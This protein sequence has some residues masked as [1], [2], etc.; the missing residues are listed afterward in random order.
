MGEPRLPQ[1][2]QGL[3]RF[4]MQVGD[5]PPTSADV[6]SMDP[7]RARWLQEAMD[8]L[9]VDIGKQLRERIAK[10]LQ[11]ADPAADG[12]SE[13]AEKCL[14]CLEETKDLCDNLDVAND[15]IKLGGLDAAAYVCQRCGGRLR[16]A[17]LHLLAGLFQ[18]NPFAQVA[19]LGC[20]RDLVCAVGDVGNSGGGSDDGD[21]RFAA[22]SALSCLVRDC[23]AAQTACVQAGGLPAIAGCLRLGDGV[24]DDQQ[25][26]RRRLRRK[27]A[28]LLASLAGE[29]SDSLADRLADDSGGVVVASLIDSVSELV[30]ATDDA[31]SA[32]EGGEDDEAA[33]A[34]RLDW[35][36]HALRCLLLLCQRRPRLLD[37]VGQRSRLEAGLASL[38][39]SPSLRCLP[40]LGELADRLLALSQRQQK[41]D[42]GGEEAV[43]R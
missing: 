32:D 33:A 41:T 26:R 18:N 11:N 10:L 36:E 7:E 21:V 39:S 8:S 5:N 13:A 29:E 9:T 43:D 34:E 27:A 14:D 28:F 42:G 23:P 30:D 15:F 35:L 4:C 37:N 2:L 25:R 3:L 31:K 6:A 17:A 20:V 38:L 1:N 40:E 24:S 16:S 19:G 12:D 22:L